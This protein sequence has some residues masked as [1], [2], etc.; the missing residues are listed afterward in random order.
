MTTET[1]ALNDVARAILPGIDEA[2]DFVKE[3]AFITAQ[4]AITALRPHI[5]AE[6]AEAVRLAVEAEREQCAKVAENFKHGE[7]VDDKRD[8]GSR[9]FGFGVDVASEWI[10]KA[11]RTG[12]AA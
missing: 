5:E 11:I 8:D 2:A 12:E 4:A 6:K 10:G 3:C 1:A 7:P 9:A